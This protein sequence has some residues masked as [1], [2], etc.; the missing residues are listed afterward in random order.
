MVYNSDM[1]LLRH[2]RVGGLTLAP[3]VT[4]NYRVSVCV[5]QPG[6]DHKFFAWNSE[7]LEPWNSETL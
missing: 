6:P 3:Q 5:L 2:P 7:A 4:R 1:F